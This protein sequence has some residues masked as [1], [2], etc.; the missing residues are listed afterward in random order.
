MF[1]KRSSPEPVKDT[2]HIREQEEEE[3]KEEVEE[4]EK[5]GAHLEL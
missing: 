2:S 5:F 4:A 3:E 1:E